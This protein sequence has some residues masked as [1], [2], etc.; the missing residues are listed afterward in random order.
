MADRPLSIGIDGRELVGKPTGVGRYLREV[1][2]VW[3][4][5]EN[6]GHTLTVFTPSEPAAALRQELSRVRWDVEPAASAGT[7]WEQWRLPRAMARVR[8]D[9]LFAAGYTAPLFPPCPYVVAIYDVSFHAHPEWFPARE[10]WRRRW[11]TKQSAAGAVR[12]VTISEFSA[13]EIVRWL[14]IPRERIA[15]A[16]PGASPVTLASGPRPPVVLFA[17]SLFARRHVPELIQAFAR[18]A[19]AVP[20]SRLVI[21]GDDRARPPVNPAGVAARFGVADRVDWHSYVPD[22]ELAA[23]Y[24]RARVFAFLSDYEGFAMTPL[25]AMARGVPPLLLDTPVAREVYGEAAMLVPLDVDAVAAGLERL[26]TDEALR[27]ELNEAGRARLS[28]FS[29]TSTAHVIRRALEDAGR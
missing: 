21:V 9:V 4:G 2:H 18:I 17:G 7:L 28:R 23:L 22:A 10:G 13:A 24:A 1:L 25:E 12:V 8:A 15:V 6:F 5:D 20:D 26:L 3:N 27:R 14:G 19:P 16:P 29:W 11:L